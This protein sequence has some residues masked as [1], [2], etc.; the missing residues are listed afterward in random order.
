[1]IFFVSQVFDFKLNDEIFCDKFVDQL[2][3]VGLVMHVCMP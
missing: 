1:M 3:Y 2:G